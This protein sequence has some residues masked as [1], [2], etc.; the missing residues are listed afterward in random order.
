[1]ICLHKEYSHF[2][3]D[4]KA[5]A[6]KEGT[7]R[8]YHLCLGGDSNKFPEETIKRLDNFSKELDE[9]R[10]YSKFTVFESKVDEMIVVNG[11]KVFSFCEHHLLPFFGYCSIGY[12]PNGSIL[13][14][15]KFQRIV[16]KVASLPTLQEDLCSNIL[17]VFDV[18]FEST[19]THPKGMGI[20]MTCI[21]TCMYG[22]GIN[23]STITIN[24][25]VL[26]GKMKEQPEARA[27]FLKRINHENILR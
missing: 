3:S 13:G 10:R 22:R 16:D 8:G 23:T 12:I 15:S 21:H 4:G 2:T 1:M 25:Q 18:I 17:N 5:I 7:A 20:A 24:S 27:E 19:D 9:K 6:D 11:I 26:K 14:L